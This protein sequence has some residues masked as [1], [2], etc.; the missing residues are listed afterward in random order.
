MRKKVPDI[1]SYIIDNN[2]DV[3]LIQETWIRKCDG[4]ILTKVKEYG[5]DIRTY[6]KRVKLE[7]GGGVC[8]ISR[9]QLKVNYIKC[10]VTYKTFEHITCKVITEIGP[11]LIINVYRRGYSATNKF[12][13]TQFLDEFTVLLDELYDAVT[14]IVI[15]GD[16]NIH[17]E[18]HV[19]SD[20][21]P[22]LPALSAM[23]EVVDFYAVLEEYGLIQVV[24]EPT[25][26]EGGTL[27]LVIKSKISSVSCDVVVGLKD[28]VCSSDHYHICIEIDCKPQIK[29]NKVTLQRRE[30]RNLYSSDFKDKLLSLN[31]ECRVLSNDV[32]EAVDSYN[33]S[34]SNLFD[35]E[36]PSKEIQVT[37]HQKQK[38]FNE[39]LRQMK[40][41]SRQAERNY[42]KDG[43]E[44][45]HNELINARNIY[46]TCIEQTREAYFSDYFD[47]ISD[48]IGLVYKK[49]NYYTH[50]ASERYL[51]THT[52]DLTLANDFANFFLEKIKT[53]RRDI[54]N[55][56]DV[57]EQ[58]R[59]SLHTTYRGTGF[60]NFVH[61]SSKDVSEVITKMP[62]KMNCFDPIAM[63]YMKDNLPH[64]IAPLKHIV[65]LSLQSGIFPEELKHG[66]VCPICKSVNSDVELHGNYRPVTTLPFLSKLLEKA[67]SLQITSYLENENLIPQYQSAYLKSHSCETALFKLTNDVQQMLSENKMIILIKLDLSAAFDTVDHGVL[68]NLLQNKFGIS[69]T[70]LSWLTSYLSGRTFSV[71]IGSV[72]GKRVL[73]VYGVPQGSILGPLLFIL[74]ISDLPVIASKYNISFQGYA[75]DSHLYAGFDPLLKYTDTVGKIKACFHEVEGWMKANYL[76]MNASKTEVLYIGK[77]HFHSLFNL[78][79][80]LG[81]ECYISSA[82]GCM[83]SL[84]VHF[85]GVM[86]IRWM[87]SEIVKV[88]NFN[89]KKIS[90]FRYI[91]SIKHKLL[92]IKSHVLSKIDYCSILLVNAPANQLNRLQSVLHK[93]IRFAHS[94]KKRDSV[95]NY[96]KDAHFLP[97]KFRLMYKSCLFAFNMLHGNCPHYMTNV[98]VPKISQ[99]FNLRSNCDN[100]L[101][102]Q[103]SHPSTLQH[104]MIHNWNCLPY[105]I[106]CITAPNLFKKHL[107]TYYF[108][109]AYPY[110][111]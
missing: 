2:I 108:N 20:L 49:V 36:C 34:L 56:P 22:M 66:S 58:M 26:E 93:A 62:C 85:N 7:W 75:D 28:E 67:A 109:T 6:R 104:R 52:D 5:Y 83:E 71:R 76:K 57:N 31:L 102:Y 15:A 77:P 45:H 87:V 54:E 73:L 37:S 44:I 80:S 14:P 60:S 94:L 18:L 79:I 101:F 105:E 50:D 40:R 92:L 12:T 64:F 3:T 84:G 55:D 53:I 90:T 100:L 11:I 106:R 24:N 13:V 99:D 74:Y 30:L 17:V 70:A 68:L 41:V 35:K 8:I 96:L 19:P 82:N 32:N 98:I 63:S 78:S 42:R 25:H 81:E 43:S 33:S 39:E 9:K 89:L 21:A 1:M 29:S 16:I 97:V 91:L 95:S 48:N 51:P 10:N 103:N 107:K 47:E 61:L 4:D 38:W 88:C 23:K 111:N 110:S 27:D 72:N 46:R 65:N 59:C 69:G 86:S